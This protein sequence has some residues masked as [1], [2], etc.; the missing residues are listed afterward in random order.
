VSK[1]KKIISGAIGIILTLSVAGGVAYAAFTSQASVLGVSFESGTPLLQVWNGSTYVSEWTSGWNF[2]NLY[3]NFTATPTDFWLQNSSTA[4]ISMNIHAKLRDGVTGDW[5][6]YSNDVQV[7]ITDF[8][9]APVNAD[10][11]SLATWNTTGFD[12]NG[13]LAQGAQHHY[14]FN[15]KVPASAGNEIV[16]QTLS[17]VNFD[18]TGSTP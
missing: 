3:P 17:G 12:I 15:V 1:L 4:P 11:H 8:G 16:S 6:D 9:V 18:F 14:S 10:W 2:N 13:P 5:T 7:A